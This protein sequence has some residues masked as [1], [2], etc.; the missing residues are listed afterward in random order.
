MEKTTTKHMQLNTPIS[1]QK[2]VMCLVYVADGYAFLT[3][4]TP[5]NNGLHESLIVP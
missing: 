5:A 1:D 2:T 3:G 4:E